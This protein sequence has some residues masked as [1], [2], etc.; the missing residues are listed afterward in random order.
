MDFITMMDERLTG[1]RLGAVGGSRKEALARVIG[2]S[3]AL[4]ASDH[5]FNSASPSHRA[6]PTLH[7]P[8]RRI[9][10]EHDTFT[11]GPWLSLV[12]R[13]AFEGLSPDRPERWARV[14]PFGPAWGPEGHPGLHRQKSERGPNGTTEFVRQR[15]LGA[16]LPLP[17][18]FDVPVILEKPKP[19]VK[20]RWSAG[21]RLDD[22]PRG[23]RIRRPRAHDPRPSG[24]GVN[25][26]VSAR[27]NGEQ[28]SQVPA[29]RGAG[30]DSKWRVSL[31]THGDA[32]V[33]LDK[34][35]KNAAEMIAR[36]EKG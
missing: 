7:R 4:R 25:G 5:A 35:R 18:H 23:G 1:C 6:A 2:R 34:V 27:R 29:V 9:L 31:G 22:P 15:R 11:P 3:L 36:I 14:R 30:G 28:R 20:Q 32:G 26:C 10:D 8:R 19:D 17:G 16:G 24:A 33:S 21:V 13:A 12:S